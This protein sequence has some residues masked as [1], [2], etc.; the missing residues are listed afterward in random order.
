[1][2]VSKWRAWKFARILLRLQ[3][4]D[5]RNGFTIEIL[6]RLIKER[7]GTDKRTVSKYIELMDK[8]Q[9]IRFDPKIQYWI[10]NANIDQM[11]PKS[12]TTELEE[13]LR[14]ERQNPT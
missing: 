10:V 4:K 8:Y 14:E 11:K 5:Y 7:L 3:R 12:L 1:M 2:N 9:Y 6:Q 13:L